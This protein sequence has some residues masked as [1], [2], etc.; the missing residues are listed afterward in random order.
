MKIFDAFFMTLSMF[1]A[2]PCPYRPWREELRGMLLLFLPSVGA[3]VGLLWAAAAWIC[4]RFSLPEPLTAA[5][6]VCAPYLATGFFHLDG[7]LD[8]SDAVL[9]RRDR[10]ERLRILKDSRVGAFAVISFGLLLT[11][12]FAGGLAFAGRGK[13]AGLL[14]FIPVCTRAA[15]ALAMTYGRPLPHSQYHAQERAAVPAWKGALL[16]VQLFLPA[17]A[18]WLWLGASGLAVCAAAVLG[19]AAAMCYAAHDLGGVSGD[20]SGYALTLGELAGLLAAAL[21]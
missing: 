10:D 15:A 17:A 13:D 21:L 16:A 2:V 6:V 9:S 11:A 18:A 7:F 1:C 5:A 8:T 20:L 3:V 12:A 14:F 4:M 19:Y